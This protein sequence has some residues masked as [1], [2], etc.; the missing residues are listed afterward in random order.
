MDRA[1][2]RRRTGYEGPPPLKPLTYRTKPCR[3]CGEPFDPVSSNHKYCSVLCREGLKTC[4]NCGQEYV[5]SRHTI[6]RFCSTEC[7]YDT[8]RAGR[9]TADKQGYV[10]ERIIV[11]GRPQWVAQHRLVME[12]TLGRPLLE[13]ESVHHVNGDRADNR[14]ENLELWKTRTHPKGVR[15]ADYH[16]AG[17][18]CNEL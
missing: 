12:R 18:R 13:S 6:G 14:L 11:E 15:V 10:L 1:L 9:T 16:C 3:K 2:Y 8:K 4:E 7:H 17:C 5:P